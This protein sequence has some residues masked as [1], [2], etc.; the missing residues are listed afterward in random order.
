MIYTGPSLTAV[1]FA[2]TA[3]TPANIAPA[4][5]ALASYTVPSLTSVD[6]VLT[7]WAPPTYQDVG[8]ELLPGGGL[9]PTQFSGLRY[10]DGSVQEL[11]LVATAD[12][13]TGNQLRIH[14]SATT[15]CVYLVDTTDPD[16]SPIRIQTT[17][18]VKAVRFKT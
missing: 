17:A 11:C 12:G 14:K 1:D 16:A 3:H 7:T 10:Q 18:G 8:W 2:L 9:F 5:Q 13:N 4:T 15:Y 6:F